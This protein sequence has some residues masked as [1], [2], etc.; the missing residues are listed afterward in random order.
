MRGPLYP[1]NPPRCN[2]RVLFSSRLEPS[3]AF[4]EFFCPAPGKADGQPAVVIVP[5]DGNDRAH[6]KGGMADC[7]A[8]ERVF[9]LALSAETGTLAR[10]PVRLAFSAGRMRAAHPAGEFLGGVGILGV[11]FIAARYAEFGQRA[12]DSVNQFGWNFGEETRG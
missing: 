6:P 3:K 7:L 2:R 8:E 11:G 5:L 12:T 9:G 10:C 1:D 4:D